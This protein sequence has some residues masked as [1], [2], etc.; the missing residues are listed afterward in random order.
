MCMPCQSCGNDFDI[1][2]LNIAEMLLKQNGENKEKKKELHKE[3]LAI[4]IKL[5]KKICMKRLTRWYLK[6]VQD[7]L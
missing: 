2:S 7:S 3:K 6:N 5:S 4:K 1:A